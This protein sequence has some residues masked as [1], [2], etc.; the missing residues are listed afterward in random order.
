VASKGLSGKR[1]S[2][3]WKRVTESGDLKGGERRQKRVIFFLGLLGKLGA[4]RSYGS[5]FGKSI[6]RK[7][8]S[9]EA[10]VQL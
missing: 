10:G 7:E 9:C 5:E 2:K 1:V 8:I 4:H 6:K 3:E